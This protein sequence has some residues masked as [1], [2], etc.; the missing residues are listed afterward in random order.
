MSENDEPFDN[1]PREEDTPTTAIGEP[2]PA[3]LATADQGRE[4]ESIW[5]MEKMVTPTK[6]QLSQTLKQFWE[7]FMAR[8]RKFAV[9]LDESR[10][11]LVVCHIST[12]H[13]TRGFVPKEVFQLFLDERAFSVWT[14]HPPDERGILHFE[15]HSSC[16]AVTGWRNFTMM[17]NS[18]PDIAL[19]ALQDWK[20]AQILLVNQYQKIFPGKGHVPFGGHVYPPELVEKTA[21]LEKELALQKQTVAEKQLA[22]AKLE[23]EYTDLLEISASA[24]RDHSLMDETLAEKELR[25]KALEELARTNAAIPPVPDLAVQAAQAEAMRL[26]RELSQREATIK[27]YEAEMLKRQRTLTAANVANSS[28]EEAQ[29]EATRAEIARIQSE[30]DKANAEKQRLI[31]E[32]QR[33]RAL[34]PTPTPPLPPGSTPVPPAG[35]G[36]APSLPTEFMAILAQ[37]AERQ[38]RLMEQMLMVIANLPTPAA[39]AAQPPI[40][41]VVATQT[42]ARRVALQRVHAILQLFE[43]SMRAAA[44]VVSERDNSGEPTAYDMEHAMNRVREII[45]KTGGRHAEIPSKT[46]LSNCS[47]MLFDY[48]PEGLSLEDFNVDKPE[49]IKDNWNKFTK[50]YMHM[51]HVFKEYVNPALAVA[52]DTFYMNLLHINLRFPRLKTSALVFVTQRLLGQLRTMEQ[53][54]NPDAVVEGMSSILQLVESSPEFQTLFNQELMGVE[55]DKAKRSRDAD[56]PPVAKKSKL[57]GIPPR[58]ELQG[59]YPCYGWIK[60]KDPCKGPTCNVPKRKGI[61]PH[62]FDPVDRGTAEKEFRDWVKKYM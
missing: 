52:L 31:A 3:P 47:L 39:Q 57:A 13:L 53:I 4:M 33:A 20:Q 55:N 30:L 8:F 17:M 24:A 49:K 45:I 36:G 37:Q 48:G 6:G 43:P 26:S 58:P 29:N 41:T 9:P 28:R 15:K 16:R 60:D 34:P 18:L 62:K 56:T 5:Q 40:I 7:E 2:L 14:M 21:R 23:Q 12:D 61:R 54:D 10:T 25:I 51:K 32:N 50:A 35:G 22:L 27:K 38:D 42:D 46:F 1:T 44:W 59:A 19:T 11:L